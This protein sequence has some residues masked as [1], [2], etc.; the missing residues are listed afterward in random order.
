MN[1]S[2]QTGGILD[3]FGME[4]GLKMIADA[5]FDA[6][7]LNMDHGLPG[8]NIHKGICESVFDA[9]HEERMER[10]RVLKETADKY[11]I[12]FYQAHAPF[13]SYVKD[14]CNMNEYLIEV[15]EK[16]IEACGY[17]QC[18]YLIIHPMFLGYDNQMDKD[19]EWDVNIERYSRLI[20]A[21]KKYDV[22]ACLEN[23]F[24]GHRKKI[25]EAIC[26][27]FNEAAAYIDELNGIAGEKRFAF[28]FDTGHAL[29]LGKDI[30]NSLL[31]VGERIETFHIHDNDGID[32]QHIAP[33]TGR[34]DW[35]RFI[36]GVKEIGFKGTLSFETFNICNIYDPELIPHAL[37]LIAE[38]VKMFARRIEG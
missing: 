33:Y 37:K 28:C 14:D 2:V 35:D 10:V 38:T 31:Q 3:R 6:V 8:S 34:L 18:R 17:L 11:G 23:M 20:P 5:G 12:S 25:Y 36:K 1:I 26:S 9:P 30:Y 29:L 19:A 21:L 13:P 32:D 7:D 15:L 4:K 24:T 27:D 22:I 16:C